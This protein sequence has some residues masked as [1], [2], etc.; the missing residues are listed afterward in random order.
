MNKMRAGD[1]KLYSGQK[2]R[3]DENRKTPR[4]TTKPRAVMLISGGK[5]DMLR[6]I[7]K[8]RFSHFY[9]PMRSV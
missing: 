1:K 7:G 6:N 2:V 8:G 5:R 9:H 4:L 3:R